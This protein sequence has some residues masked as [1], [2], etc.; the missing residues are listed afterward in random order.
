[1]AR[2]EPRWHVPICLDDVPEPGLRLDVVADAKL[3]E[4]LAGVAG[5]VELPRLKAEIHVVR[6]GR[7]LRATGRVSATVGQICVVTLD[8]MTSEV[9]EDFEVEFV[10]ADSSGAMTYEGASADADEPAEPIIDGVADLGGVLTEFLLLGI[11]RYPRKPGA[12]FAQPTD[13]DAGPGPFAV[14]AKLKNASPR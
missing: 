3:R 4:A 2:P 5:L 13:E 7:G 1:M 14:L 6:H 10:P 8:P 12:E 11:D 9:E